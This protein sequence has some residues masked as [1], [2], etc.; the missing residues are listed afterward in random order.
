MAYVA[1][2]GL[3]LEKCF[4][5]DMEDT[6]GPLRII[7]TENGSVGSGMPGFGLLGMEIHWE[8][9]RWLANVKDNKSRAVCTGW[10][11]ASEKC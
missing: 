3:R 4:C 11:A 9:F 2:P 7:I 5:V 10:I 1:R 6:F 8:N